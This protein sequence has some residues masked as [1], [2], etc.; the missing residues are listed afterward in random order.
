[1]K[2]QIELDDNKRSRA[3]YNDFCVVSDAPLEKGGL[4][5]N[6]EPFDFFVMSVG[7][8][9]GHY[10]REFCL[11]RQLDYG[12][13]LVNVH[14]DRTDDKPTFNI[15]LKLPDSFPDKYHKAILLA[16]NS[17]SIKKVISDIPNFN[18]TL[19]F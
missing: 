14:F 18:V 1:M 6:P 10:V 5:E 12:H 3:I 19:K 2:V 17:C 9:A 13:I 16:V 15:E 4:A 11:V 8:C 7:L